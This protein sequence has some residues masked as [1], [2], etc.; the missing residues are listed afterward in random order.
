MG[1]DYTGAASSTGGLDVTLGSVVACAIWS[2]GL[3]F[4]SPLQILLV[5]LG[6]TDTERPSD[7]MLR[8]L[9]PDEDVRTFEDAST[10]QRAGLLAFF[11]ACGCGVVAAFDWAFAGEDTW[12]LS[13]GI[14]FAML[15]FVAEL[16]SPRC[17]TRGRSSTF[18][19]RSTP[20]SWRS[21]TRALSEGGG[22]TGRRCLA[23]FEGS[24]GEVRGRDPALRAGP[25]HDDPQ[26]APKRGADEQRVLQESVPARGGGS[27]IGGDGEGPGA[28]GQ[29]GIGVGS[30]DASSMNDVR[31]RG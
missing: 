4:K 30:R 20:I 19:R 5:F 1:D 3:F 22:V 24:S 21:R 6:R 15:S 9:D 23:R 28:L 27:E 13:A 25:L 10:A 17:G 16:G 8:V 12:G 14:G 26:L 11:T 29:V 7:W 31:V 18:W 2:F